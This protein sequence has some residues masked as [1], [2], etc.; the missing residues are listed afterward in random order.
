MLNRSLRLQ[1]VNQPNEQ[2]AIDLLQEE[3]G[4]ELNDADR[5]K[6]QVNVGLE[7]SQARRFYEKMADGFL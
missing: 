1:F 7:V 6:G 3:L 5:S 4:R 2:A